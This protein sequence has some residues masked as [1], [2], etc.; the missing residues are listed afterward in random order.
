MCVKIDKS[1]STRGNRNDQV[2]DI[3]KNCH[4]NIHGYEK[5]IPFIA[6]SKSTF[7]GKPLFVFK[8]TS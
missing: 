3:S 5:D 2:P 8:H 1:T 7:T 6:Q 4:N